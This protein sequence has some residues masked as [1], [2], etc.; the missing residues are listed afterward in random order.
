MPAVTLGL[1]GG[2]PADIGELVDIVLPGRLE[3]ILVLPLVLFIL[4]GKLVFVGT[5]LEFPGKGEL[6]PDKVVFTP[7]PGPPEPGP[8]GPL[9]CILFCPGRFG[10]VAMFGLPGIPIILFGLSLS[11]LVVIGGPGPRN[12]SFIPTLTNNYILNQNLIN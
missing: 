3:V 7:P 11:D 9:P 6:A 10:F 5:V 2:N 8:E 1:P 4:L 12:R